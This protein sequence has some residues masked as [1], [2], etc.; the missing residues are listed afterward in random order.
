MGV[1][2]SYQPSAVSDGREH[3]E[4]TQAKTLAPTGNCCDSETFCDKLKYEQRT[5]PALFR[6]IGRKGCPI[7]CGFFHYSAKSPSGVPVK[8][9]RNLL[10]IMI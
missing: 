6:A 8:L 2:I 5:K 1:A 4:N 9:A 10:S 7:L 3:G